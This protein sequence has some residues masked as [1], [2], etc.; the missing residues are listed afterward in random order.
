MSLME[1]TTLFVESVSSFTSADTVFTRLCGT[2]LDVARV[3]LNVLVN[4]LISVRIV[5]I[6]KCMS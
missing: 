4:C 3:L 6:K 1:L 2:S 5:S